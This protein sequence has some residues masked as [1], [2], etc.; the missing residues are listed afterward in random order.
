MS[1]FDSS[2]IDA[3][4]TRDAALFSYKKFVDAGITNP[5]DIPL[6]APAHKLFDEWRQQL[7][8]E[9]G[10]NEEQKLRADLAKTMFYVDA[11]FTDPEYLDEV[12]KE[13]FVQSSEDAPKEVENPDRQETRRQIAEAMLKVKKLLA[14]SSS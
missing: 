12:L 8:N 4:Q 6:D 10:D 9:A 3:E 14:E 13:W 11:G 5:D 1:N 2:E 7:D